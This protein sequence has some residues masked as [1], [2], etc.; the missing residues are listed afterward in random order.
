MQGLDLKGQKV[1]FIKVDSSDNVI[2]V[3][4]PTNSFQSTQRVNSQTKPSIDIDFVIEKGCEF[5]K[6]LNCENSRYLSWEHCYTA[7]AECKELSHEY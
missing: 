3:N 2:L 7:F 1:S 5:L 6:N 4:Q